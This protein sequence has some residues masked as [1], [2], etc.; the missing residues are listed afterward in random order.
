MVEMAEPG[1]GS[2]W[3]SSSRGDKAWKEATERVASRNAEARKAGRLRRE[4]YERARE[5]SRRA[6]E[7]RR[8]AALLKR[9]RAR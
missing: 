7:E 5:S 8:H 4:A 9:H 2:S 3:K 6:A 1:D